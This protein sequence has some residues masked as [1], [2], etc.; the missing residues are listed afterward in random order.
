MILNR[1][2]D[3]KNSLK[4]EKNL[5]VYNAILKNEHSVLIEPIPIKNEKQLISEINQNSKN[6]DKQENENK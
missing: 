1:K 6:E 3:I 5:K 2:I 4:E